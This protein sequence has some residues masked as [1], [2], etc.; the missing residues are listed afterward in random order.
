MKT[1]KFVSMLDPVFRDDRELKR[2][3]KLARTLLESLR[4]NPMVPALELRELEVLEELEALVAEAQQLLGREV[5][6]L[7]LQHRCHEEFGSAFQHA[8][9]FMS[10]CPTDRRH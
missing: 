1:Y 6:N 2:D 10:A 5:P 3:V 9:E 8:F 7:V 4:S